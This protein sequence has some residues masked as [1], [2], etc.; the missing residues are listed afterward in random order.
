MA[1]ETTTTTLDDLTQSAKAEAR[2]VLGQ[3][4]LL[5]DFVMKRPLPAGRNAVDFPLYGAATHA[6]VAE[7][8]D[9]TNQAV[10]TSQSTVTPTEYGSMTTVTRKA[11]T[12]SQ[13]QV[14]AD[15][16]RLFAEAYRDIV[17]QTI[18]ALFDGFSTAV[19]TTNVDLTEAVLAQ[20]VRQLR[21]NK[22]PPPYYIVLTPHVAE[23]LLGVYA[24]TTNVNDDRLTQ[25]QVS[26]VLP[27]IQ[28]VIP[29]LIDNLAAGTSTGQIDEAD[30]KTAVFS[31]AA[32]GMVSEWDFQVE[33]DK[34]ISLRAT[35]IVATSS[36]AVAE[37][38]D[39]Y[40]IEVL[41]DNK[42]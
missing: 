32:I 9:L 29:I 15:I 24:T 23:D 38:K 11:I 41:V 22:A 10:S 2:M 40:G 1:D 31:A 42:D 18:Y 34:D 25:S 5:S 7:A 14:G 19:G 30:T 3:T 37:I 36:W 28:G 4:P 21:I 16:G 6:S 26:G 13:A 27:M 33:T 12:N 35:E 20:A 17:N 8:T 39:E